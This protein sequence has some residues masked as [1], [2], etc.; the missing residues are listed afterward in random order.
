MHI[1][2]QKAERK[3]NIFLSS[4]MSIYPM[5]ARALIQTT[6]KKKALNFCC[7][8]LPEKFLLCYNTPLLSSI[9]LLVSCWT[10][11]ASALAHSLASHTH[12]TRTHASSSRARSPRKL[13]RMS[14]QSESRIRVLLSFFFFLFILFRF[15]DR[16]DLF[17]C[18][19]SSRRLCACGAR[20]YK[21]THTYIHSVL[22]EFGVY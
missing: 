8:A 20:V 18:S 21:H 17:L 1:Y 2:I 19:S 9:L 15:V 22:I 3:F 7:I 12:N 6:V 14:T 11:C 4:C 10:V 16:S 13:V 5:R